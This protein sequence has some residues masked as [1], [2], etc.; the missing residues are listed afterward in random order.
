[1]KVE[2][3][4][5]GRAVE[6]ANSQEPHPLNS[7]L[8]VAVLAV[9]MERFQWMLLSGV[10]AGEAPTEAATEAVEAAAAAAVAEAVAAEVAAEAAEAPE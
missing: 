8:Y 4:A 10:G 3:S 6:F 1:M 2:D 5:V 9:A 7:A